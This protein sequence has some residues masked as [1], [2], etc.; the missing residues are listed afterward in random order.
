MRGKQD[1]VESKNIDILILKG[2]KKEM[3]KRRERK[4]TNG[5][6]LRIGHWARFIQFWAKPEE[7]LEIHFLCLG[8]GPRKKWKLRI[9]ITTESYQSYGNKPRFS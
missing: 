9:R 3:E 7:C 2:K 4:N 1:Q 6:Y 5:G 8:L